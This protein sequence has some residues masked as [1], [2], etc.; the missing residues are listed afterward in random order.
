MIIVV[1]KRYMFIY[2]IPTR[3]YTYNIVLTIILFIVIKIIIFKYEEINLVLK[4][5]RNKEWIIM[6]KRVDI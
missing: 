5:K 6:T 4:K 3:A 2:L 1:G